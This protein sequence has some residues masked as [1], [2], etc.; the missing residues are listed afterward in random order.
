MFLV[1]AA[2][3]FLT[4][5][6]LDRNVVRFCHCSCKEYLSVFRR[7]SEVERKVSCEDHAGPFFVVPV[8]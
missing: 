5:Y 3:Y 4:A 1:T 2:D 8:T 7:S 6:H